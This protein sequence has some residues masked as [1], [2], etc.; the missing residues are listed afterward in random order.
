MSA[1]LVV[2]EDDKYGVLD[3]RIIGPFP[4]EYEATKFR[5]LHVMGE[6]IDGGYATCHVIC[7]SACNMT[8]DQAADAYEEWSL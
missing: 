1:Y 8:P 4:S 7:D 5:D 2:V 3:P 6:P